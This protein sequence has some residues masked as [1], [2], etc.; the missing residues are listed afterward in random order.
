MPFYWRRLS[1]ASSLD[2]LSLLARSNSQGTPRPCISAGHNWHVPCSV[3]CREIVWWNLRSSVQRG[4]KRDRGSAAVTAYYLLDPPGVPPK[5]L[6]WSHPLIT[7]PCILIRTELWVCMIPCLRL[8]FLP[9]KWRGRS[10][11]RISIVTRP[12]PA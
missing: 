5:L 8:P 1:G 4:S 3:T 11:S 6:I 2:S 7:G 9:E 10:W 12:F